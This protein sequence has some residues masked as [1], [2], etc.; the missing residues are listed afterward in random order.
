MR[1]LQTVFD[2]Q[3]YGGIVNHVELLAKGFEVLGHH[4]EMVILRCNDRDPR[5]TKQD[6]HVT[7]SYESNVANRVNTIS[8]WY[9]AHSMS[10]GSH[11][12][13]LEWREYANRFDVIIHQ[14]P[15]PK[16]DVDGYWR[17]LYEDID[18]PQIAI[19]HDAHFRDMYPHMIDIAEHLRAVSVTNPAG[20]AALDWLPARRCFIGAPHVPRIWKV[21]KPWKRRS[22]RF[23]SAHVWKAWKHMDQVLRALVELRRMETGVQNVIG[24]DGIEARYMRSKEKCKP[25]YAGLWKAA[26]RAGMSYVGLVSPNELMEFYE[27]SRVMVDLSYSSKF[28]LLGN[29]FNRSTIEAYNGGCVPLVV[30][31]NMKDDTGIFKFK[32][33][34]ASLSYDASVVEIAEAIHDTVNMRPSDAEDIVAA[35]RR[36]FKRHFDYRKSAEEFVRLATGDIDVGIYGKLQLGKLNKQI[37]ENRDEVLRSIKSAS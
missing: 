31:E 17:M 21:Q 20:Y 36:M 33:H 26:E 30:Y 2:I 25:K 5:T 22:K 27:G 23:V 34:Y 6:T 37:M 35:G 29:H 24:G 8:G 12:R 10:Y 19:A 28:E 18:A 32:K 1:I 4:P 14:L 16:P 15:V 11:E 3:D 7:G 9:G 13:I